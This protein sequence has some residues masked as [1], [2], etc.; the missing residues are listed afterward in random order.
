MVEKLSQ[1]VQ[2]LGNSFRST[3]PYLRYLLVGDADDAAVQSMDPKLRRTETFKA[4]RRLM[5]QTTDAQPTIILFE[6]LHWMDEATEAF[7]A[8]LADSIPASRVLC[9][10]TQRP[11]YVHPFGDRTY[12]TRLVLSPLSA[13]EA[14]Q[15]ARA[16]LA[17]EQL[18]TALETLIAQKVDG[19]PFFVEEVIK[20]LRESEALQWHGQ[21]VVLTRPLEDI[22]VPSAIQDL[23]MARID[24]LPELP[25][26]T[27]QLASWIVE[28]LRA[29]CWI[30]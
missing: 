6:D 16:I 2:P 15:M 19:N 13:S 12:H 29:A 3:L 26:E 28:N 17:T 18:P 27:L 14:V 20:S 23:L 22:G 24:R 4:L 9:L 1:G 7:L 11:G 10:L 25:K 8:F 21:Q 30:R 5:L